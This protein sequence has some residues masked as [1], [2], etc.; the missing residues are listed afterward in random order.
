MP[1]RDEQL[2]FMRYD[3]GMSLSEIHYRTGVPVSTLSYVTRGLRHTPKAYSSGIRNAYKSESYYHLKETGFPATQANRFRGYAVN[4]I[5]ELSNKMNVMI[6]SLGKGAADQLF[7]RSGFLYTF[8]REQIIE[9][10]K[11]KVKEGIEK[12]DIPW[13][14]MYKDY[15]WR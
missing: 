8:R 2:Q 7:E 12:S 15:P 3:R 11:Q 13:E 5:R 10:M 6:E 4:T 1:W 9:E 14:E